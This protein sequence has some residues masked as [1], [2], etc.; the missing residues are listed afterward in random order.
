MKTD[1]PILVEP[2]ARSPNNPIGVF[3][4][5]IIAQ[6]MLN[7]EQNENSDSH[8]KGKPKDIDKR[9]ARI[10]PEISECDFNVVFYHHLECCFLYTVSYK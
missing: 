3:V 4:I 9:I 2:G 8:P 1:L 6:F 5:L 7:I 10:L